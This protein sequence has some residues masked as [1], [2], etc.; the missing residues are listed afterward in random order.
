LLLKDG[1]VDPRNENPTPIKRLLEI[2]SGCKIFDH[3]RDSRIDQDPTEIHKMW[4]KYKQI[5]DNIFG[6]Q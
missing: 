4:S 5:K 6:S 1:R 2:Q 3:L